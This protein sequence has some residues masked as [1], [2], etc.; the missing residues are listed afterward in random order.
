MSK[1]AWVVECPE[2]QAEV[3]ISVFLELDPN[4]VYP[5]PK[6]APESRQ[7]CSDCKEEFGLYGRKIYQKVWEARDV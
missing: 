2:C 6:V 3:R 1:I 5:R 4:S 7:V